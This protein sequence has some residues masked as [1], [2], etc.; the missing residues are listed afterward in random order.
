MMDALEDETSGVVIKGLPLNYIRY[1]DDTVHLAQRIV[2]EVDNTWSN[3]G[4]NRNL[5]RT[6]LHVIFFPLDA[7]NIFL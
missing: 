1:T 7:G 4:L 3:Y 5:S 2:Q 6:K